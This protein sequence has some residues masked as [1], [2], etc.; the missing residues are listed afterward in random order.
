MDQGFIDSLSN[1]E[2]QNGL[3]PGILRSV[4]STESGFNPNAVSPKGAKGIAQFMPATAA[5]YGVDTSDPNSSAQGAAR[6]LGD[7]FRQSGGDI[8]KTLAGWNWGQ[9][10]V[11]NKGMDNMPEET[12]N[13]ISRVKQGLSPNGSSSFSSPPIKSVDFSKLSSSVSDLENQSKEEL[14]NYQ[15][16]QKEAE[17]K[18]SDIEKTIPEMP[19]RAE[20]PEYKPK[21]MVDPTEYSEFT[22]M[23]LA[24]AAIGGLF[25]GGKGSNWIAVT[26]TMNQAIDGFAK[27]NMEKYKQGIEDY[28]RKYNEAIKQQDQYNKEF[29]DIIEN[30]NQSIRNQ[31]SR[32]EIASRGYGNTQAAILAQKG[33]I[34]K[35]AEMQ[36]RQDEYTQRIKDSHEK[37]QIMMNE[38][39]LDR[40][41]RLRQIHERA[42]QLKDIPAVTIGKLSALN[43]SIVGLKSIIDDAQNDPELLKTTFKVPFWKD[44]EKFQMELKSGS[45]LSLMTPEKSDLVSDSE[46]QKQVDYWRHVATVVERYA[47]A[48]SPS[49]AFGVLQFFQSIKPQSSDSPAL[50]MKGFERFYKES[51]DALKM[52]ADTYSKNPAHR[53][54]LDT[55]LEG[56]GVTVDSHAGTQEKIVDFKDL[57]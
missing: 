7:L 11:A 48:T 1:L 12:K 2:S 14:A 28:N 47:V 52:W 32:I 49:R 4:L 43:Q 20:I 39:A 35:L 27:G 53:G 17:G 18:I 31:L 8:D 21:P 26:D 33:D 56:T 5:Q 45:M 46:Y 51:Q 23:M 57:K 30:K 29:K 34:F 40:E 9:G 22:S 36:Q 54:Q 50:A 55:F 16:V 44:A 10:N 38:K 41:N 19:Q 15:N 42:S 6:M 24:M 3:P 37:M 25:G 13:F